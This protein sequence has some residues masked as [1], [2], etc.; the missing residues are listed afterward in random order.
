MGAKLIFAL[1]AST[2]LMIAPSASAAGDPVATQ[3]A[4]SPIKNDP[5]KRICREVTPT[6]TRMAK[7]VCRSADEWQRDEDKAQRD[8]EDSRMG[9]RDNGCG[10]Q[11]PRQ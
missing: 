4:A 1:A 3:P 9:V 5:G 2:S 8:I 6:G 10:L 7:R 11:C